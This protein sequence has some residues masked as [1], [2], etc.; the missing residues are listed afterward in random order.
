MLSKS[1]VWI[2]ELA[3]SAEDNKAVRLGKLYAQGFP[4]PSAFL[5]PA[6]VF[7]EFLRVKR[8]Y[9]EIENQLKEVDPDNQATLQS[10]SM[11][12][13]ELILKTEIPAYLRE[14]ILDAYKSI[15]SGSNIISI[16]IKTKELVNTGRDYVPVVIRSV[17]SKSEVQLDVKGSSGLIISIKKAWSSMFS[18]KN[19]YKS[20]KMPDTSLII[21]KMVNAS[22]SGVISKSKIKASYGLSLPIIANAVDADEYGL[23]DGEVID[24]KLGS[25]EWCLIRSIETGSISK[26]RVRLED[27]NTFVLSD[28]EILVLNK[29]ISKISEIYLDYDIEWAIDGQ[30]LYIIDLIKKKEELH[31]LENLL[32]DPIALQE[33]ANTDLKDIYKKESTDINPEPIK[34]DTPIISPVLEIKNVI[35]G[36]EVNAIVDMP[37]YAENARR[38]NPDGVILYLEPIILNKGAHPLKSLEDH[39]NILSRAVTAVVD[40]FR[41]KPLWIKLSDITTDQFSRLSGGETEPRENNPLLGWRGIRRG[42]D[43]QNLLLAEIQ[44]IKKAVDSGHTN[45]GLLIPFVTHLSE[46]RSVKD[47]LVMNQLINRVKVGVCIQVP[48]SISLLDEFIKEGL[49]LISLELESFTELMLGIDRSNFALRTLNNYMHPGVVDAILRLARDCKSKNIK[50]NIS[51]YIQKDLLEILKAEGLASISVRSDEIAKIREFIGSSTSDVKQSLVVSEEVK[52]TPTFNEIDITKDNFAN[53]GSFADS[54]GDI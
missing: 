46:L 13:Q 26:E 53:M 52:P 1:T 49:D 25:K 40:V 11:K 41:D 15:N 35:S 24:R 14:Q 54:F 19:L 31:E 9:S 43:Q 22:K 33:L 38:S 12:I 27:K 10:I 34:I 29:L 5:I 20:N 6:E 8:V 23:R 17:S 7:E 21:Q 18:A 4:I 36:V 44:A 16:D 37:L 42:L 30:R 32:P 45:I 50:F 28:R 47:I 39:S 51:G 48:A 3:D 2:R